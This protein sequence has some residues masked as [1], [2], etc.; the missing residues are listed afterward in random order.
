[1]VSLRFLRRNNRKQQAVGS[2]IL[3]S[4]TVDY[5]STEFR[6]QVLYSTV[7]EYKY[8]TV[9]SK[10]TSTVQYCQTVYS[11]T[12]TPENTETTV[13]GKQSEKIVW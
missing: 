1:M 2:Y 9:L 5:R 10:S 6:V 4:Y 13:C 11:Q 7:K 12:E 8:C 3:G